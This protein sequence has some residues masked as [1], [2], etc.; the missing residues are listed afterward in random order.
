MAELNAGALKVFGYLNTQFIVNRPRT[1][2][3]IAKGYFLKRPDG[4]TY[5]VPGPDPDPEVGIKF[6][7]MALYDPTHP[8]GVPWWQ[9]LLRT[10]LLEKGYDGWMHD[11][12][13]YTPADAVFANGQTGVELRNAYPTL[14][15]Q[16]AAE[17]CRAVKPD[18]TFFV[19]SG[20]LGSNQWAPSSWPGDQHTDWTRGR[21]LASIIPAGTSVGMCGTNI[22]GPDI[23]GFFDAYDGSDAASSVEL[24]VR[25]CQLGALTPL[26]RD[27]LGPKRMTNPQAVDMWTN[28]VTVETW[29]RYAR[30]HNA[31]IA[32]LYAYAAGA[33]QTGLPTMRHLALR[34]P[35]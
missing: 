11:F 5:L 25:W 14:Y 22:W 20:A 35:E 9:G 24:W 12:G 6:G 27:H 16:T 8:E 10:L 26:M 28:A 17:L 18:F 30:L 19:R 31:L 21:G 1:D 3:G 4:E 34:W 13:E 32:Y 2:E 33:S 29:R 15:Q 7:T 23:G